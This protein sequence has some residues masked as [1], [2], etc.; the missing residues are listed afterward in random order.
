[1][2]YVYIDLAIQRKEDAMATSPKPSVKVIETKKDA[3]W[4]V[5]RTDQDETKLGSFDNVFF[6]ELFRD[7]ILELT[8]DTAPQQIAA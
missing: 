3:N 5:R 7:S 8:K 4:E 2:L 1:M 6:A